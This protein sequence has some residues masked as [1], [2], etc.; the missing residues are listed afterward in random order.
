[1]SDLRR[2]Q[3]DHAGI[4]H[5][6]LGD[7]VLRGRAGFEPADVRLALHDAVQRTRAAAADADRAVPCGAAAPATASLPGPALRHPAAPAT[8]GLPGPAL[9][10]PAAPATAGFPGPALRDPATAAAHD[11]AAAAADPGLD[12]G[13]APAGPA[14]L[15]VARHPGVAVPGLRPAGVAGRRVH[16]ADPGLE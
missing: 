11:V 15:A 12:A 7:A 13:A 3:W 2:R 6:G 8:A 14:R 5:T 4:R 1:S 9:R 10:H 16:D